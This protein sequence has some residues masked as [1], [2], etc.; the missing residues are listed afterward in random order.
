MSFPTSRI[1]ARSMR[2]L[3]TIRVDDNENI[4]ERNKASARHTAT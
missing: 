4:N 3:H 2:T 1:S